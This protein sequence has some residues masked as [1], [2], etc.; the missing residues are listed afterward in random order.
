MR[1]SAAA[2]GKEVVREFRELAGERPAKSVGHTNSSKEKRRAVPA[3][4]S[5]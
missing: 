4:E 2:I 3:T 1:M 5:E